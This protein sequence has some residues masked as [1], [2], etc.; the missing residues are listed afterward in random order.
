MTGIHMFDQV[1]NHL[2]F[3]SQNGYWL[4]GFPH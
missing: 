3:F 1:I 2:I 4:P